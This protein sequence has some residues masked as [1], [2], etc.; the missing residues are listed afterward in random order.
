MKNNDNQRFPDRL[1]ISLINATTEPTSPAV[2][3]NTNERTEKWLYEMERRA[4]KNKFTHFDWIAWIFIMPPFPPP[5]LFATVETVAWE[6]GNGL[7]VK[8]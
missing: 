4:L 5:P 8:F 1:R 2:N 6:C 7:M 3:T